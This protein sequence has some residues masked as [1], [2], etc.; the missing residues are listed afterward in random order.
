MGVHLVAEKNSPTERTTV[1][2]HHRSYA[3]LPYANRLLAACMFVIAGLSG[4]YAQSPSERADGKP[5]SDL[6]QKAIRRI[7][8]GHGF[9][10]HAFGAR[11]FVRPL[12][13]SDS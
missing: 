2:I 13:T 8:L 4:L 1:T 10:A 11:P 12:I 7:I 5:V 6:G 3:Y 9:V